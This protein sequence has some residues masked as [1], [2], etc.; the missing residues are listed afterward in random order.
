MLSVN[1]AAGAAVSVFAFGFL[2]LYVQT[3]LPE[4]HTSDRS[5][6]IIG[7]VVGLLTLL[8]ALVLGSADLD[9]L[10]RH[11]HA[12]NRVAAAFRAGARI[13]SRD[14]TVRS[15]SRTRPRVDANGLVWAHEHS[16]ETNLAMADAYDASYITWPR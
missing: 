11:R 16:G 8:L 2:G 5:R 13:R 1:V 12:K 10:R 6:D 3:L 15:G 14:E 7:G 4:A 9:R